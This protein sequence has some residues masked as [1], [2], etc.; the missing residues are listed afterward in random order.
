MP[1]SLI[2]VGVHGVYIYIVNTFQMPRY[3]FLNMTVNYSS[4]SMIGEVSINDKH[5]EYGLGFKKC[6]PECLMR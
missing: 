6:L 5:D 3:M 2:H 1:A 4:A